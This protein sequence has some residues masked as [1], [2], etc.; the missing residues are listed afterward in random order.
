[1]VHRLPGSRG[2]IPAF[3]NLSRTDFTR[4]AEHR[5]GPVDKSVEKNSQENS[6]HKLMS[7]K[8][9]GAEAVEKFTEA[10]QLRQVGGELEE[11]SHSGTF[12][13]LRAERLEAEA[14]ELLKPAGEIV[15]GAAAK[16][17]TLTL[18]Q[19]RLTKTGTSSRRFD[20]PT[21]SLCA[22]AETGWN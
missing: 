12:E 1:M 15:R 3:P 9:R 6:A 10:Q 16:Q 5:F 4:R 22:Q 18:P 13:C 14:N 2:C 7:G 11:K 21:P 19:V 17:W 20:I 8:R